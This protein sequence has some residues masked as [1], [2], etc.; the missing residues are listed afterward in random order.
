MHVN[1]INHSLKHFFLEDFATLIWLNPE[2]TSISHF[3]FEPVL[4][5]ERVRV[6]SVRRTRWI[7]ESVG[8]SGVVRGF[9]QERR[10][11]RIHGDHASR[12]RGRETDRRAE[13]L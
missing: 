2:T 1:S 12:T 5:E 8:A 9:R 7:A 3:H 6:R 10:G 13:R 11:E 4:W